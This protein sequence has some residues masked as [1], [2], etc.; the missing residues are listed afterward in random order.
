MK[1]R[2]IF[3]YIMIVVSILLV[4][5]IGFKMNHRGEAKMESKNVQIEKFEEYVPKNDFDFDFK[6]AQSKGYS[7]S[8]E[9]I[10]LEYLKLKDKYDLALSLFLEERLSIKKLDTE[11]N[12]LDVI[13]VP[14]ISF[15]EINSIESYYQ[16]ISHLNSKY[17]YLRNNIRIERLESDDVELLKKSDLENPTEKK[18]ILEMISKTFMDVLS[19]KFK[20]EEKETY[21]VVYHNNGK[22]IVT[23]STIVFWLSYQEKFDDSGN[24]VNQEKENMKRKEIEKLVT[25]YSSI[26]SEELNCNVKIFTHDN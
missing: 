24:Y 25:K 7:S 13:S 20:D 9:T 16:F 12:S 23:N 11:L 26:F 15:S 17:I 8:K 18:E 19:V 5:I 14:K 4:T 10:T 3:I 6:L 22:E 2:R 1:N 21:N